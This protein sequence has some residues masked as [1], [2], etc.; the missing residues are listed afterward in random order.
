M[1]PFLQDSNPSNAP[2]REPSAVKKRSSQ[3]M[4]MTHNMKL[5]ESIVNKVKAIMKIRMI[6][7]D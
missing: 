4:N 5:Y 6:Y 7:V 3:S 2:T 1:K